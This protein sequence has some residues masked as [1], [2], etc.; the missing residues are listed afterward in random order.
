MWNIQLIINEIKKLL[1][2]FLI[3]FSFFIIVKYQL[4]NNNIEKLFK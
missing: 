3:N 1:E 2:S 4:L